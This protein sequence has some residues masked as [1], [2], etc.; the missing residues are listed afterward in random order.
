MT[1]KQLTDWNNQLDCLSV[2]L[3]ICL[4]SVRQSVLPSLYP[5]SNHS[6]IHPSNQPS[7]YPFTQ[8]STTKL[9]NSSIY[10]C[11]RPSVSP[12]PLV[13]EISDTSGLSALYVLSISKEML[14]FRKVATR[15]IL[16]LWTFDQKRENNEKSLRV[17]DKVRRSRPRRHTEVVT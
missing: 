2:C 8:P 6:T 14:N 16:H 7:S 3:S 1:F 9:S 10:S 5:L 12:Y 15:W 13:G 4:L 17:V 11:V